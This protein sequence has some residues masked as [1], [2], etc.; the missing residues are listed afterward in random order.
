MRDGGQCLY[1]RNARP[2]DVEWRK[3]SPSPLVENL[4]H[5]LPL[6]FGANRGQGRSL[7]RRMKK[8]IF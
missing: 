5:Y 6:L 2:Y 8:A 7:D 1:G 4:I 3:G